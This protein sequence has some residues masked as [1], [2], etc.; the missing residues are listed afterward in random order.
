MANVLTLSVAELS[1]LEALQETLLTPLDHPSV[2][3]WRSL[4]NARV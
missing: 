3:D 1:L 4:V 2:D